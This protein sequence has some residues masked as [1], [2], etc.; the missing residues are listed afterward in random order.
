MARLSDLCILYIYIYAQ[1]I[2]LLFA[3]LLLFVLRASEN[4]LLAEHLDDVW[5]VTGLQWIC[6][7]FMRRFCQAR[8]TPW[9]VFLHET[10]QQIE[11]VAMRTTIPPGL[12]AIVLHKGLYGLCGCCS[13][14]LV[15]WNLCL[16]ANKAPFACQISNVAYTTACEAR[17]RLQTEESCTFGVVDLLASTEPKHWHCCLCYR[18]EAHSFLLR[19]T[20]LLFGA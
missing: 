2:A 9:K 13:W 7:G 18:A 5:K 15:S 12:V 17:Q 10:R 11:Y 14:E 16:Y 4:H 20:A 3:C 6:A 19:V 8:R 1:T